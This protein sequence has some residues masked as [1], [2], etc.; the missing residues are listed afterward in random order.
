MFRVPNGILIP[1]MDIMGLKLEHSGPGRE[2]LKCP[3][4]VELLR[5]KGRERLMT[6]RPT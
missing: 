5:K 1:P 6:Q 2:A 3:A 4:R